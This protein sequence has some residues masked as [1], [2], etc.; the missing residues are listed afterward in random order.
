MKILIAVDDSPHSERAV[1]FVTRI[2]WP[3]GSR[4]MVLTVVQPV[5]T[6]LAGPVETGM[7]LEFGQELR[8][9]HQALVTRT[10]N[11]LR[12]C[13]FA[14]EGRVVEGD[15]RDALLQ[16]A[17]DEHVDLIVVG[18]HG[19]TGLAKLMLG[20][21]SSTAVTHAPCSVLVIKKPGR[22]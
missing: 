10:E 5:T 7:G 17:R 8:E 11:V 12:T 13:G 18:S 9:R 21:V 22:R 19:R 2:R 3:A 1:E 4:L 15:P 6:A 20:S 14:T 16:I